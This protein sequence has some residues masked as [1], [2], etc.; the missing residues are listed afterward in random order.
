MFEPVRDHPGLHQ[1]HHAIREHF[2]VDAKILLLEQAPQDGVRYA[3]DSHLQRVPV[4]DKGRHVIADGVL[5]G[6]GV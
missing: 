4:R 5:R 6:D 3:A 1:V 2:G